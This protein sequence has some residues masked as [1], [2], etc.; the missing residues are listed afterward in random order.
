[1]LDSISV[2]EKV[3]RLPRLE[4]AGVLLHEMEQGFFTEQRFLRF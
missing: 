1:M 4:V 2:K 3:S